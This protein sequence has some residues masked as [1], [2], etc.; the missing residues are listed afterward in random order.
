MN[1]N[2]IEPDNAA[3]I[4][5]RT[6]DVFLLLLAAAAGG[7]DALSLLGLGNVFT[8]ALSGNTILLGIAL[9]QGHLGESILCSMVFL[10]FVPG[11]VLG[12]FLLRSVPQD[13]QW[14]SRVTL[15][16]VIESI[17]ILAFVLGLAW[18]GDAQ[19]TMALVPLVILSAFS[20]GLQYMTMIRLNVKGVT[21]TFV[22]STIVNLACRLAVPDRSV[23][24]SSTQEGEERRTERSRWSDRTNRFLAS[25]WAAYFIGA[26]ASAALTSWSRVAAALLPLVLICAIV[27]YAGS[28]VM[29]IKNDKGRAMVRPHP[30]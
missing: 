8:S 11:A 9:V 29:F 19:S 17:I 6:R 22:T 2:I 13:S 1:K 12:A 15:S 24:V 5:E 18:T 16:L 10:G 25:V 28:I 14:N 4:S 3:P 27:L 26:L 20:M 30:K 7:M 23:S 21:T